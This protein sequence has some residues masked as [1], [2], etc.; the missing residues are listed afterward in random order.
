MFAG[1]LLIIILS[2]GTDIVMHATGIY[3]PWFQPMSAPLWLFATAY[4]II[5]GIAGGYLTARLAPDRPMAHALALAVVGLFLSIAGAVGTWNA[6][7]ECVPKWY[8]IGLV[9]TSLPC[10]WLGG[11]LFVARSGTA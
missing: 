11:K 10:A 8:P 6:G 7:P 1:V 9:L 3:P 4:R 5:Y 2:L